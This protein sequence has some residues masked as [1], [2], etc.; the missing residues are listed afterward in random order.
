LKK[1]LLISL[2]C[3]LVFSFAI[4][5]MAKVNI[6]Y[7]TYPSSK[8]E[9]L[10]PG[11]Y[12]QKIIDQFEKKY[13]EVEI[14]LQV[15]P[16]DGG[17]KKVE[18]SILTGTTPDIL[19]DNTFRMGKFADAG[20]L[21]PFDLTE[22]E[23]ND[24]FPFAI[25]ACTFNGKMGLWPTAVWAQGITVS[26]RIAREA[27]ALDLLPLDQPDRTWTADEFRAFLRKVAAAKL[28]EVRGIFWHL[29][30]ANG[31]HNH[32]MLMI[33]G[34]GGKPFIKKDGKYICTMNSPEAIEGLE[35]YLEIYN[36]PGCYM[37]GAENYDCYDNGN[38]FALGIIATSGGNIAGLLN[39]LEG[40]DQVMAD[41]DLS[42]FPIP[43][44]E[45]IPN[46]AL[47]SIHAFG[48]FD[49]GDPEKAKYAQL[50]IRYLCK[51]AKDFLTSQGNASPVMRSSVIPEVYQK[52]KDNVDVQYYLNVLPGFGKDYG[53]MCP[54]YQ[55]YKEA[56][57]VV[58]QG[59]VT[60]ELTAKEALDEMT[61]KVNKLLD[62]YYEE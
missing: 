2:I 35:Y 62:E 9:G 11:E 33:Q 23:R 15:L 3:L 60:G 52:Y 28:P 16:Y 24:F 29:G 32:I 56:W 55:Q 36:T 45:G 6:V 58:M 39:G 43:S 26:K 41:L 5:A 30:D 20:L 50:F 21:V 22:E 18:L 25:K 49:N 38:T 59:A 40:K 34:F 14:E 46:S 44:K 53:T 7:W 57:R 51:N 27:G 12:E 17:I 13:P 4:T 42:I 31:Q 8:M 47:L 37:E 10:L 48:V 1:I 54:V 61:R 19:I